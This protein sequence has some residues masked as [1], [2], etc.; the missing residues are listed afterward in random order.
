MQPD[1]F[2]QPTKMAA[3]DIT[4]KRLLIIMTHRSR[5]L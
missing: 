3:H 2:G 5:V 4:D 1:S